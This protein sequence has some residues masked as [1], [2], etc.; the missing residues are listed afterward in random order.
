MSGLGLGDK[1]RSMGTFD[2]VGLI[3]VVLALVL[4]LYP[5]LGTAFRTLLLGGSFNTGAFG[6]VYT[7]RA[8]WEAVRNTAVILAVAVPA[9]VVLA[10][11]LAW[12]N[13]R[14]DARLGPL[15][16]VLPLVPL[17]IPGVALS[18]GWIFLADERAGY[19]NAVLRYVGGAVGIEIEDGPLNIATWEGM[20]FVY[21]LELVPYAYLLIAAALRDLDPSLEEA[22]RI[23]GAGTLRTMRLVSV[24]LVWPAVRAAILLCVMTG[25]AM[26]SVPVII[27]TSARINTISVYIVNT[28]RS[29]FPPRLD[30]AFAA[31]LFVVAIVGSLWF[32][33]RRLNVGTRHSQI[34]G[35]ARAAT[36]VR[37]GAWKWPA[38]C[39]ML[40]FLLV[41]GIA[42]LLALVFV[43][44]QPF[45]LASGINYSAMNLDNYRGIFDTPILREALTTSASLGLVG[46]SVGMVAAALIYAFLSRHRRSA[47]AV[48]GVLKFPGAVTHVVLGVSFLVA[49]AGAPFRLYGTWLILLLAYITI[50]LPQASIAAGAAYDRVGKELIEAS[51]VSGAGRGMTF[52]RISL[53]LMAPGLAAGWVLLFVLTLSELSASSMLAGSTNPVVGFVIL[54]IY[55]NGSYGELAAFA[56]LITLVNICAVLLVTRIARSS[57]ITPR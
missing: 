47:P 52:R 7:S 41:T 17:M 22:S 27:G 54:R 5:L 38:R 37:L 57:S 51:A 28:V 33:E 31:G 23:S 19:A 1:R 14:T 26:F 2:I 56:G 16:K 20:I 36:V 46:A 13:E 45:W 18:I 55:E 49:F 40:T 3:L 6:R 50:Y 29:S 39:L 11:V 9:A 43:A 34:G 48:D 21:V 53:P 15:S 10:A 35:K 44:L 12:L 4:V 24:P 25:I 32:L 30:E 8:F 42:P